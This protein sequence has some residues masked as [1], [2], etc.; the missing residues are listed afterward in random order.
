MTEPGGLSDG[1][2]G[3]DTIR[4]LGAAQIDALT[5][6]PLE[7]FDGAVYKLLWQS[8]KSVAGVMHIPAGSEVGIHE[9]RYSHHHMWVL[10]GEAEMM[11]RPIRAGTYLHIPTGVDHGF[12]RVGAEGCTVFY[13]YLRDG[14]DEPAP[15]RG[16]LRSG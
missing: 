7:G 13:L 9:H 2:P 15:G 5:W 11:G 10:D 4:A 12:D 6:H 1:R 14:P 16:Q 8:G 3:A